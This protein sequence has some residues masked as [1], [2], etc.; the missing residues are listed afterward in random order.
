MPLTLPNVSKYYRLSEVSV[1]H[2]SRCQNAHALRV[3]ALPGRAI[4]GSR[5][6]SLPLAINAL[7]SPTSYTAMYTGTVVSEIASPLS[8]MDPLLVTALE[9]D[10][11]T[12][13]VNTEAQ[14]CLERVRRATALELEYTTP[15]FSNHTIARVRQY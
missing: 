2:I 11:T 3:Y 15:A 14:C 8:G 10:E 12:G 13:G 5:C 1:S 7:H 4:R 9:G 6:S